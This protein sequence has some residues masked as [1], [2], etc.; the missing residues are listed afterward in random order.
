MNLFAVLVG[1]EFASFGIGD[2]LRT[3][4]PPSTTP[5]RKI[6]HATGS[7]DTYNQAP[8]ATTN[9]LYIFDTVVY[10]FI[11]E[12]CFFFHP[13]FYRPPLLLDHV[14]SE[15][16][17]GFR[18]NHS[19]LSM[20]MN[21]K[22]PTETDSFSGT[23]TPRTSRI[24]SHSATKN[25]PV[26]Q[27][28]GHQER[29]GFSGTAT[30]RTS[31]S[32]R[33]R[34]TKNEPV[35]QAQRHQERAGFSGTA[36]PSFS[37]TA[38]PRTSRFFR[39]S[40]TKNEPVFQAQRHKNEPVFRHSDT[41]NE[42]D[43]QAQRHQE[44]AGFSGTATAGFSGTATP[45]TSRFFRHS[46]TKNEPVFQAQRHQERAGFSGTATPRTSRCSRNLHLLVYSEERGCVKH[47][48]ASSTSPTCQSWCAWS[49]AHLSPRRA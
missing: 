13:F 40:D 49:S 6:S 29:A 31:R 42:P 45:R 36:T 38:T 23:A 39:H 33:H 21:L 3:S 20:F 28:Q 17:M 10:Q 22:V 11:N 32:F 14:G 7:S 1:S 4:A 12:L 27:A 37:G 48:H 25:Q 43:F 41:K 2:H 18:I 19:N 35:F 44:R 34:D 24:F 16:V 8:W 30:P 15:D 46:D 47:L 9:P 26:F 5:F